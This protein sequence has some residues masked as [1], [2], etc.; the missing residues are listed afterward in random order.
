MQS[1][2]TSCCY[3][4]HMNAFQVKKFFSSFNCQKKKSS[5]LKQIDCDASISSRK[6]S[7]IFFGTFLILIAAN[8]STFCFNLQT[9]IQLQTACVRHQM[10]KCTWNSNY[11]YKKNQKRNSVCIINVKIHVTNSARIFNIQKFLLLKPYIFY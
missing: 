11:T 8:S 1:V 10:Q 2:R 7:S 4:M 9:R 6:T 5:Y 3:S